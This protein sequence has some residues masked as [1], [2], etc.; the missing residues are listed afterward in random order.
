MSKLVGDAIP[1]ELLAE[2]DGERLEDKVG[3]AYL[4]VTSDEDG[5][6]RP[7]MLSAGEVL[8]SD[9]RTLRFALWPGGRTCANLARGGPA[10]F[11][12][13]A[14][15]TV[16]YVR[17][18]TTTLAADP[19]VNLECFELAIDS[20]ESDHHAGMPVTSG[21]AFAVERGT[22]EAVVDAWRRQLAALRNAS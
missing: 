19:E 6:P 7:C 12:H 3:P 4:L 21:I 15:G 8:A 22:P 1:E 13:V 10:L 18:R 17:G 11:C 5:T 16:L 14:P 9:E 20:V 2:L